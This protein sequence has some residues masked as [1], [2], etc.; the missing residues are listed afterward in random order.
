MGQDG[1]DDGVACG[2]CAVSFALGIAVQRM[3]LIESGMNRI[4]M[5]W[6]TS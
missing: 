3:S 2:K 4:K 6:V 5:Q 1:A